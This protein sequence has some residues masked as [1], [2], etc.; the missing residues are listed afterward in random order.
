MEAY[1]FAPPPL[2]PPRPPQQSEDGRWQL[3]DDELVLE[4][5]HY[6]LLELERVLVQHV[7]WLLWIL[8]GA[9]TL[10]GFALAFLQNWIRTPTAM[11]GMAIGALLLAWGRRGS[12]RVRLLRS[13]QEA[14][15]HALPGELAGWQKLAA[16]TNLRI[17]LRHQR[18]AAEALAL[19]AAATPPEEEA[20]PAP[21]ED[22]PS[23][24]VF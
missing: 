23:I 5:R 18:A 3:S 11:L 15:H 8:L 1:S 20:G 24:T 12:T 19:L 10:G 13:T 16:E 6:S 2:P 14:A 7:N 17:H 4:G 9:F 21:G 22:Y